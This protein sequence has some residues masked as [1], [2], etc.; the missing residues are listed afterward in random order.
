MRFTKYSVDKF[1]FFFKCLMFSSL[2]L[3]TGG[4]AQTHMN[5]CITFLT[6]YIEIHYYLFRLP[7]L[8]SGIQE[9]CSSVM[10]LLGVIL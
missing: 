5:I 10:F 3:P 9:P 4:T 7:S 1:F 6:A 2:L 8:D